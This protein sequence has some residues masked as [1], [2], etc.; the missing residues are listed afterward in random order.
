MKMME[1]RLGYPKIMSKEHIS[2]DHH[3]ITGISSR[4]HGLAVIVVGV[5]WMYRSG[6]VQTSILWDM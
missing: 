3:S 2:L 5:G 6:R 4:F 1:R